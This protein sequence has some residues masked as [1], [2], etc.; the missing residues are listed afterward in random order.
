VPEETD[1]L[2]QTLVRVFGIVQRR[3]WWILST[4]CCVTLATVLVSFVM[5][6]QYKSEATIIVEQQ[7]VPEKYVTPTSTSDLLQALQ[8]MTQD[9]LSRTRLLQIINEFE[10]YPAERKRLGPDEVVQLMRKSIEIEPLVSSQERRS[11]N[12]FKISFVGTSPALARDVVSRLTSLFIVEN[13]KTREEQ[14]KG[15]TSF[16][17]D[18]LAAAQA[19]LQ[20]QE[21]R[22]RDFK[23]QHL[24]ELPQEQQGNLQILSG[25]QMQLQNTM[26]ALGRAHEQQVYLESL[27]AQYRSLTPRAGLNPNQ[28]GPNRIAAVEKQLTDLRTQR[29]ALV[30]HYTPEHPDVVNIDR[31]IAQ[32][33][34]LLES[35]KKNQKDAPAD[36]STD[37]A[38]L[39]ITQEDDPAVAHLKS[40]FKALQV[41]IAN[42]TAAQKQLQARIGEYQRR[43]S[44]TPVREQE[45]SDILRD[46]TLSQQ[47]YADLESKKTQ[48]ALATRLVQNQQGEQFRI[49]D[50]ASL[51]TRP[52]SPDRRKLGLMGAGLGLFLGVGLAMA[53]E[54]KDTSF[55]SE[56]EVSQLLSLPFVLGVPLLLSPTEELRRSRIR[57]VEWA[58]SSFLVT[59]VLLV[60]AF[61]VW[62]G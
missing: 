60:E 5:P 57:I 30:A 17:E 6:A 10:L 3:R 35:L 25:L 22:L 14:A 32:T 55:R 44:E 20:E 2:K 52:S 12:A 54:L 43:L 56:K 8:A 62:R 27:L 45:L 33:E 18:Q 15:T 48:S 26:A 49:V 16:L 51:P 21:K 7:Q 28:P 53:A 46:Y 23:M 58:G 40:Q 36:Q 29:A 13:L 11:A 42:L 59:V 4:F 47:N 24:G 38:A 41:E 31:Q 39:Q 61:V 37:A 34:A 50:A 19:N 1:D 9:I